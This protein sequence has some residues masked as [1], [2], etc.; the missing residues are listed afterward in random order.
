[1]AYTP[2]HADW[3]DFP[4]MTTPITAAALEQI[5]AGILSASVKPPKIVEDYRSSGFTDTQTV[6][7]ALTA[8]GHLYF[9]RAYTITSLI[10]TAA[11]NIHLT[12]N[13]LITQSTAAAGAFLFQGT[14]ARCTGLRL[15]G[16]STVGTSD[17]RALETTGAD[18]VFD[19]N[20]IGGFNVAIQLAGQYSN[21]VRNTI[22]SAIGTGSGQGYGVV[23]LAPDCM[24]EFNNMRNIARHAVYMAG[25]SDGFGGALRGHA[26]GNVCEMVGANAES[27][28]VFA[29]TVQPT[30]VGCV[31][32]GN[33]TNHT[34]GGGSSVGIAVAGDVSDC[35]IVG[36]HTAGAESAGMRCIADGASTPAR[37]SFLSNN[38][39][40]AGSGYF[41]NLVNGVDCIVANNTTT[42]IANWAFVD[43]GTRTIAYNNTGYADKR[44]LRTITGA[45]PSVL[46][47]NLFKTGNGGATSITS[48]ADGVE[49]QE[50]RVVLDANTTVVHGSTIKLAGGS[51]LTGTANDTVALVYSS[52]VWYE[53]GRSVN[54]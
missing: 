41:M 26:I 47:G 15:A 28:V 33:V 21:A 29:T 3:K 35:L 20:T 9:D 31:I 39:I 42:Q 52:S 7:A 40:P 46:S 25:N 2:F 23:A 19:N 14:G 50:I 32:S 44:P 51:N 6:N 36:N 37:I 17:A 27:I 53:T 38:V 49:G 48:F 18:T 43:G 30:V 16:S 11:N 5:E 13:G 24:I 10:T 54:G 34:T 22:T 12:G 4:D 1:M 45:T 8:G